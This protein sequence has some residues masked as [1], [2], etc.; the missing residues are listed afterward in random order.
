[1]MVTT[2]DI[3]RECT[4]ALET[5]REDSTVT[6]VRAHVLALLALSKAH[7]LPPHQQS[8]TALGSNLDTA[9]HSLERM[10]PLLKDIGSLISFE[11]LPD[12]RPI[13]PTLLKAAVAGIASV[14]CD[15]ALI[16]A[17][18]AETFLF[19]HATVEESFFLNP[20]LFR[21][22][23]MYGGASV[24]DMRCGS[25]LRAVQAQR[26]VFES[27]TSAMLARSLRCSM[28]EDDR[29][30]ECR[31]RLLAYLS[32]LTT[33]IAPVGTAF[34]PSVHAQREFD[35]MFVET[36]DRVPDIVGVLR[37]MGEH[38]ISALILS[39]IA[40]GC[41]SK[42]DMSM[43]LDRDVLD[44]VITLR[45]SIRAPWHVMILRGRKP[46]ERRHRV[47]FYDHVDPFDGP[48]IDALSAENIADAYARF[49]STGQHCRVL[50]R[51]DVLASDEWHTPPVA[52]SGTRIRE[53]GTSLG[54]EEF[55]ALDARLVAR[56]FDVR[57]LFRPDSGSAAFEPALT[58]KHLLRIAVS[59]APALKNAEV[60][61]HYSFAVWWSMASPLLG[62]RDARI[63]DLHDSF[64]HDICKEG[65]LTPLQARAIFREWWWEIDDDRS[66][67]ASYGA[68]MVVRTWVDALRTEAER[69]GTDFWFGLDES[70]RGLLGFLCPDLVRKLTY[71]DEQAESL[72]RSIDEW[73]HQ[74]PQH[75]ADLMVRRREDVLMR[76]IPVSEMFESA[77]RARMA[78]LKATVD[79]IRSHM[80]QLHGRAKVHRTDERRTTQFD[81]TTSLQDDIAGLLK[82]MAPAQSELRL[83]ERS[84]EPL[85]DLQRKR[86]RELEVLEEFVG[87]VVPALRSESDALSP[88]D[89][90]S[91]VHLQFRDML[92]RRLESAVAANRDA[93]VYDLEHVWTMFEEGAI[94]TEES[95]RSLA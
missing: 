10:D 35:R 84:L 28:E 30:A 13:E 39:D 76:T 69:K 22:I 18:A 91:L 33:T 58:D 86:E 1:M 20:L 27:G 32:S 37:R 70:R 82:R 92:S 8:L 55:S 68:S 54:A 63:M 88:R 72:R 31:M 71:H 7:L 62:V 4:A 52:A 3:L 48:G 51:N 85:V 59:S 36:H 23:P 75:L 90:R 17:R 50:H 89:A 12:G 81:D 67:L 73:A 87:R 43:L 6:D 34:A 9:L 78:E 53:A 47:L 74:A 5:L 19:Q 42:K 95:R 79:A 93:I 94:R 14:R 29:D 66:L 38:T 56:G 16:I 57:P 11:N 64:E 60:R 40:A 61:T 41:M 45:S 77:A 83:L 80:A 44:C 25:G 2:Q 65:V 24:L 21:L 26:A 15:D 49:T 46:V